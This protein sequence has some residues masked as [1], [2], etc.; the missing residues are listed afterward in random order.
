MFGEELAKAAYA[1]PGTYDVPASVVP[2]VKAN[3]ACLLGNHGVIAWSGVSLKDA[4]FTL[5]ALENYCQ[6]H[7]TV[8]LLGGVRPISKELCEATFAIRKQMLGL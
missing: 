6:L 2:F 5:E 7:F 8:E 4:Y 3:S 1:Q